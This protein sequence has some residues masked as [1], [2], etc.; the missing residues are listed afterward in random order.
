MKFHTMKFL[1]GVIAAT[2]VSYGVQAAPSPGNPEI[3]YGNL[4]ESQYQGEFA[5]STASWYGDQ[6]DLGFSGLTLTEFQFEYFLPS[7]SGNETLAFR[8]YANDGPGGS[9]GTVLFDQ[10]AF[11]ITANPDT[12]EGNLSTVTFDDVDLAS[13]GVVPQN[14]TWAV[15]F[16]GID[17]GENAGLP[18]YSDPNPGQSFDDFWEDVGGTW[19]LK[20]FG[21]SPTANFGAQVTAVPEPTVLGLGGLAGLLF[22]SVRGYRRFAGRN[23]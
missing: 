15:Q 6:I 10:S 23:A 12:T 11:S 19:T 4:G 17:G 7:A 1:A 9:P 5:P 16:S 18:I 20:N 8:L 21:G 3:V 2:F 14:F 22:L 13:A